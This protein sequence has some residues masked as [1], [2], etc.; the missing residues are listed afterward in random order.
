MNLYFN[1][2]LNVVVVE[3]ANGGLKVPE[4][5]DLALVID[6]AF[7]LKVEALEADLFEQIVEMRQS[8][9][10]KHFCSG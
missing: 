5:S 1:E 2:K 8:K 7:S 6:G 4:R 9:G 10:I 3:T